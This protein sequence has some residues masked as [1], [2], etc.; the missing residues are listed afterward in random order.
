MKVWIDANLSP[1]LAPWLTQQFGIEAV[2]AERLGLVK[3]AD[4]EIFLKAREADVVILTKDRDFAE[5]V[6]QL[7]PPPRIVWFSCGNT[8]NAKLRSI[9]AAQWFRVSE[10]ILEGHPVIELTDPVTG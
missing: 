1:A 10:L 4:L 9:L 8:T 6:E 7:G 5:L 2:S 3:S